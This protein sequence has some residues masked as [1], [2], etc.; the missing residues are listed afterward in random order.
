MCVFLFFPGFLITAVREHPAGCS[1]LV[2]ER[3][4]D[5]AEVKKEGLR[6]VRERRRR[7]AAYARACAHVTASPATRKSKNSNL[8]REKR[9]DSSD[10]VWRP[11]ISFIQTTKNKKNK[12]ANA[13][14]K[15]AQRLVRRARRL[16]SRTLLAS[17][18][19][20]NRCV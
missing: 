9:K 19:K 18:V 10:A 13:A 6:S 15:H 3:S 1:Y 20:P 2:E 14:A 5:A 12:N 4:G 17:I 16:A 11:G 8:E 7:S